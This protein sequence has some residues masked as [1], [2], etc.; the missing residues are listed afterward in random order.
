MKAIEITSFGGPEVLEEREMPAPEP[1]PGEALIEV[2]AAGVNYA[3]THQ[4]DDTY[5][6]KTTL[7]FV[8]GVEAAGRVDGQ[9]IVALLPDAGGYAELAAAPRELIFALPDGVRDD[10]ALGLVLQGA[11][12]GIVSSLA[13]GCSQEST[14]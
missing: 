12:L 4:V 8:P 11:T 5:L 14:S 7:P 3:D 6:A 13:L 10:Q 1:S 9:R 2:A